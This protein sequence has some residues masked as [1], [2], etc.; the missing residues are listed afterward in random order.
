MSDNTVNAHDTGE[1][2]EVPTHLHALLSEVVTLRANGNDVYINWECPACHA[3]QIFEREGAFYLRGKCEE[4][5]HVASLLDPAIIVGYHAV[6]RS[7]KAP[8]LDG[9]H[10]RRAV[11]MTGKK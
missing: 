8:V 11:D 3:Q 9:N 2:V 1:P 7:N 4:C 6:P 5:Q 10:L